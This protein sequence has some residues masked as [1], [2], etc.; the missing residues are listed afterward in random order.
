MGVDMT[1]YLTDFGIASICFANLKDS[2]INLIHALKGS[3]GYIP[4]GIM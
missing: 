4:P 3:I 1:T 2:E